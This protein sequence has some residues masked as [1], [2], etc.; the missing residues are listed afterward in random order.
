MREPTSHL[1][2]HEPGNEPG[3]DR[4]RQVLA[5]D[6]PLPIESFGPKSIAFYDE[7]LRRLAALPGVTRVAAGNVVPWRDAGKFG[8]FSFAAEG[9]VPADGAAPPTALLRNVSPGYF[10]TLAERAG[11]DATSAPLLVD[12]EAPPPE[13]V[14]IVVE[15]HERATVPAR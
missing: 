7:T 12:D 9:H 4:L 1:T 6:V 2:V 8:P 10:A 11:G 15:L 5:L 14:D 13:L 3:G